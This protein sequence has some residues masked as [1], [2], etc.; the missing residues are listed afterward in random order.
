MK[1]CHMAD[2]D[3]GSAKAFKQFEMF[4]SGFRMSVKMHLY[5]TAMILIFQLTIIFS[6]FY[7]YNSVLIETILE[8]LWAY[9]LKAITSL[10][11]P[12]HFGAADAI[13]YAVSELKYYSIW[14]VLVWIIYP[15]TLYVFWRKSREQF[16]NKYVGGSQLISIANLT[17]SLKGEVVLFSIGG[18]PF[19]V[20]SDIKHSFIIG[21][22]G[23]GKTVFLSAV[24]ANLKPRNKGIIYD[25]K[26]DYLARSYDPD[27]DIIFNPLDRL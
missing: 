12:N 14:S 4:F 19:P 25:F 21:R 5:L 15:A 8:Y 20:G 9:F 3:R 22:P 13:S 1:G 18:V 7:Y 26:G 16:E 17:K 6:L 24:I 27:V 11:W 10:K 23:T 2:N